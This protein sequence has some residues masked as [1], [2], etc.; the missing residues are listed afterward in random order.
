MIDSTNLLLLM[1]IFYSNTYLSEIDFIKEKQC[2]NY[3]ANIKYLL[4]KILF[5]KY[6]NK[7]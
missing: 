3:F 4:I 5:Y 1:K 7:K 6:L 2:F